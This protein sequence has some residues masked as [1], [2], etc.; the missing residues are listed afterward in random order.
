MDIVIVD[1]KIPEDIKE[2][3]R[4]DFHVVE[5]LEHENLSSPLSTHPDVQVCKI[6]DHFVITSPKVY[7]YYKKEL[8]KYDII[9]KSGVKNISDNY[10][11]DSSYNLA[12]NG[13]INIH[14]KSI[15]D[16][17]ILESIENITNVNQGYSKCNIAFTKNGLITSDIGI[18]KKVDIERK[19]LIRPGFI[20]LEPFEYGFIG[21]ASGYFD[22]MYFLGD[23]R[24]HPDFYKIN[25][26]LKDEDTELEILGSG[27]LSDFGSLIFLE[28]RGGK[29][30]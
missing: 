3:L 30:E 15:T 24:K 28:N 1:K 18:Y 10:P 4:K 21:G 6:N 26:F 25:K 22:K 12:S 16:D 19:L 20:K 29:Y 23:V 17:V 13:K 11:N 9:V 14:K 7:N 2:N 5:T 27:V 8:E